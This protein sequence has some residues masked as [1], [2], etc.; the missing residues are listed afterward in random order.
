MNKILT[1]H[2]SALLSNTKQLTVYY[3]TI[4]NPEPRFPFGL[5]FLLWIVLLCET[6]DFS[7]SLTNEQALG[8]WLME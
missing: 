3:E 4:R 5:K 2:T 1:T 6:T 7:V 8:D